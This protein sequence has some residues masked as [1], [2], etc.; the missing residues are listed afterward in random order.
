MGGEHGALPAFPAAVRLAGHGLVLRE[1]DD[2]D[3]AVLAELFDDPEIAYRTPVVS[4]FDLA[5]ARDYLCKARWSRAEDLRLQLA[6]TTDGRLPRGEV[7]LIRS[8]AGGPLASIGYSV[9]AAHRGRHLAARAVRV[10]TGYAHGAAGLPRV[11]LEIEPDNAP[12]IA[13]A[14][15]A[16]YHPT[17]LPPA[18]A[19]QK[20]RRLTLLTWAH[21]AP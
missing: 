12:S 6:I 21:E 4:P 15:E 7:L 11:L 9:G 16:G 3:L 17:G 14:Q 1:W 18:V 5:A 10:M 13:V 8:A 19:E 20:G 2:D